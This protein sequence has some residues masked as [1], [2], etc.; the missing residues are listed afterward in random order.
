MDKDFLDLQIQLVKDDI[1]WHT[2]YKAENLTI[3]SAFSDS[4]GLAEKMLQAQK[5]VDYSTKKLIDFEK[6]LEIFY[7]ARDLTC[8]CK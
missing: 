7:T 2:A 4:L 3:V 1:I 5:M 6:T 8:E